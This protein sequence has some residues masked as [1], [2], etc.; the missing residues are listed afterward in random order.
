[1]FALITGTTNGIGKSISSELLSK[2]LKVIGI[3]KRINRSFKNKNFYPSKLNIL[4]KKKIYSF[5]LKLKKNKK[6]PECFI[7]NAGIN[8]YDNK[9]SFNIDNFKKCFDIN[10]FGV[11]NFVDAIEK[12]NIKDKKI[13]CI[14]STSNIIP[15][16]KALGY[17]S[18]KILL[19]KNF[20]LLNYNKT[21][22]YK[23]II[24]GPVQ[25]KISRNM[26]KPIG[27]AGKIYKVLQITSERA[28]AEIISFIDSSKK[29]LHITLFALIV[30]Y[31]IKSTIFFV[32][33]LYMKNSKN[34]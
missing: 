34:D 1:M 8:I 7:L 22:I 25:T 14:S 20:D 17:Y 29:T 23:T 32:P 33:G 3:D 4:N 30:Y 18:S 9:G 10:F 16:P 6:L 19:K 2:N 26:K 27:I 11:M 31:I 28:A 24:L 5:L 13:V 21:N 12:L 15:N